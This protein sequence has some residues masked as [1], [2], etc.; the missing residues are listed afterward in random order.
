MQNL[1]NN[2]IFPAQGFRLVKVRLLLDLFLMITWVYNKN[3]KF[4]KIRLNL[5]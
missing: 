3:V 5:N 4:R 1:A 2:E